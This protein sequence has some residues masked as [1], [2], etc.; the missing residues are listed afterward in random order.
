MKS[1]RVK[2]GRGLSAEECHFPAV[3]HQTWLESSWPAAFPETKCQASYCIRNRN[4]YPLL[5][6]PQSCHES[7]FSLVIFYFNRI[8]TFRRQKS[9]S[10]GD[11]S[12]LNKCILVM[13]IS[14]TRQQQRGAE[15]NQ[16]EL[17]SDNH[18]VLWLNVAMN[19]SLAV[20]LSHTVEGWGPVM[21]DVGC[22]Q[23]TRT[24]VIKYIM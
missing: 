24:S 3:F 2:T 14:R 16:P 23:T 21:P 6:L 4:W 5:F 9:L 22:C 10:P 19:H 11:V 8:K 17:S 12:D 18:K 20:D 13:D 15:V 1:M 7:W